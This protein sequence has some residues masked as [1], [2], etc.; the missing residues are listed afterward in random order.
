MAP[1]SRERPPANSQQ[2]NRSP[3]PQPLGSESH[4]PLVLA[5]ILPP[6]STDLRPARCC[7]RTECEQHMGGGVGCSA[8]GH[9]PTERT[10]PGR[11]GLQGSACFSE[12][13]AS[14]PPKGETER[15]RP[16][17]GVTQTEG[18]GKMRPLDDPFLCPLPLSPWTHASSWLPFLAPQSGDNSHRAGHRAGSPRPP[19][20]QPRGPHPCLP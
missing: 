14:I 9:C 1:Q 13:A 7:R 3:V 18:N 19:P 2:G 11:R 10:G 16:R 12:D 6:N 17:E 4:Q 5:R 15:Q 20:S 8:P